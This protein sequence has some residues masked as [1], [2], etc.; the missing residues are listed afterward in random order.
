MAVILHTVS[1]SNQ[2]VWTDDGCSTDM[3]TIFNVE[4]DLPGKFSFLCSLTT[5]NTRGFESAPPTVCKA[6]PES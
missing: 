1:S 3:S 6:N 2:P 5:N 4:A